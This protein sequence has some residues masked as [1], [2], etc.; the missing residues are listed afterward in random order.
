MPS[1]CELLISGGDVMFT[2]DDFPQAVQ[3]FFSAAG[4]RDKA[5][6]STAYPLCNRALVRNAGNQGNWA[7]WECA[8][9]CQQAFQ[10]LKTWQLHVQ[11]HQVKFADVVRNCDSLLHS[12][13]LVYVNGLIKSQQDVA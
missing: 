2:V 10:T 4:F 13:T 8:L 1:P 5:L 11:Q 6:G 9:Q 12:A 7:G 3:H